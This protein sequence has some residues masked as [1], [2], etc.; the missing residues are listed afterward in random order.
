MSLSRWYSAKVQVRNH[1]F[2]LNCRQKLRPYLDATGQVKNEFARCL[3]AEFFG[4][5]LFQMFGGSAPAKDT[6]AP[7][8]N[9]FALVAVSKSSAPFWEVLFPQ[10]PSL[11]AE[12]WHC[13][14]WFLLDC[15]V[16]PKT[17]QFT[18]SRTSRVRTSTQQ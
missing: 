3:M 10:A 2:I 1:T 16:F 4:T 9:G 15:V 12:A 6:T 11:R 5:L 17:A 8:A 7:A 13:D 14:P 18:R